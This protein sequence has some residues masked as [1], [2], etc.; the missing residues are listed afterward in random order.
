MAHSVGGGGSNTHLPLASIPENEITDASTWSDTTRVGGDNATIRSGGTYVMREGRSRAS[1]IGFVNR[2]R[3]SRAAVGGSAAPAA[4][5]TLELLGEAPNE[6]LKKLLDAVAAPSS[7][8][9]T[10]DKSSQIGK[11]KE[12]LKKLF[13]DEGA[14]Q[15]QVTYAMRWFACHLKT[16]HLRTHGN[17]LR[18]IRRFLAPETI[19]DATAEFD[20]KMTV[21]DNVRALMDANETGWQHQI[22]SEATRMEILQ[23]LLR[24]C[25][26]LDLLDVLDI[27]LN[28]YSDGQKIADPINKVRL[29]E[30]MVRTAE[31]K[32]S[33][34]NKDGA[35]HE[36]DRLKQQ[37]EKIE[38]AVRESFRGFSEQANPSEARKE[39][40]K[41]LSWTC[42]MSPGV[43]PLQ[44]ARTYYEQIHSE[45][46]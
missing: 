32:G 27:A 20:P 10:M 36:H 29:L 14:N 25:H 43:I 44:Q 42:V 28:N 24:T 3:S 4:P 16:L 5:I 40:T 45:Q 30:D 22:A 17:C 18:V 9:M 41:D 11:A 38:N 33:E 23:T 8:S 1:L 19:D 7:N 39:A 37:I 21:P 46:T 26:K 31:E 12:Y 13:F 35:W 15:N 6:K 34:L 2:V